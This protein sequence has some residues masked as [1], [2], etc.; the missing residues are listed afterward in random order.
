M[1]P[2][3]IARDA[4]RAGPR[5]PMASRATCNLLTWWREHARDLE[6]QLALT[7]SQLQ[8]AQRDRADLL[9]ENARLCA[10]LAPDANH[11]E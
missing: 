5:H 8:A 1:A 4:I 2:L 7:E 11:P 6:R 10:L 3:A 9:I